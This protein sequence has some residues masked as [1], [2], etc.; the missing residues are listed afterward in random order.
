MTIEKLARFIVEDYFDGS[1]GDESFNVAVESVIKE[2]KQRSYFNQELE[3][4]V[5]EV[6]V[7]VD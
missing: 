3:V 7:E 5:T 4:T 1:P 2:L 6:A